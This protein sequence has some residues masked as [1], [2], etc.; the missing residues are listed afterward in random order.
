MSVSARRYCGWLLVALI[1]CTIIWSWSTYLLHFALPLFD[2]PSQVKAIVYTGVFCVL[3]LLLTL[4]YMRC[5]YTHP[6]KVALANCEISRQ[7]AE[8]DDLQWCER[9]YVYR[10]PRAHHCSVCSEC[11]LRYDHHCIFINN[12]VGLHNH[13]FFLLFIFYTPVACAFMCGTSYSKI[14]YLKSE[15]LDTSPGAINFFVMYCVVALLGFLVLL[16]YLMHCRLAVLNRTTV[17]VLFDPE[18]ERYDE[19]C[20]ANLQQRCGSNPLLW[21]LPVASE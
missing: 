1:P 2:E 11:I 10:P 18:P 21:L 20:S 17:E 13:K 19:G 7:K 16:F 5:V 12:C 4:S 8:E 14:P 6:G 15:E 9:C 3:M